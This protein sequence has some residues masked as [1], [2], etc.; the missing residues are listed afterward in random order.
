MMLMV[1][2][3]PDKATAERCERLLH[4]AYGLTTRV[5]RVVTMSADKFHVF[6]DGNHKDY[7]RASGMAYGFKCGTDPEA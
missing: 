6:A 3:F 7:L 1:A 5:E 2:T 4:N